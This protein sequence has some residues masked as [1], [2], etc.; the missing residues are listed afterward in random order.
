MAVSNELDDHL[1]EDLELPADVDHVGS[2]V[3]EHAVISDGILDEVGMTGNRTVL[4]HKMYTRLNLL[5]TLP[6]VH[7]STLDAEILLLGRFE[8]LQLLHVGRPCRLLLVESLNYLL[9]LL[10]V[11]LKLFII[12]NNLSM[13]LPLFC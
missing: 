7:H 10:Q 11:F 2:R 4:L 3:V 1:V 6:H 9:E 13:L 8:P 12:L 5:D